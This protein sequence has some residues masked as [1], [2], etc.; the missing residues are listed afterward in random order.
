MKIQ[1]DPCVWNS[2]EVVANPSMT[3]KEIIVVCR[4]G[5]TSMHSAPRTK[6]A[7]SRAPPTT[8]PFYGQ[9]DAPGRSGDTRS[10]SLEQAQMNVV[11]AATSTGSSG[12]DHED[13]RLVGYSDWLRQEHLAMVAHVPVDNKKTS[14]PWTT[15][16]MGR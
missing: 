12:G 10:D 5:Q 8:T 11:T 7:P 9:H 3:Q 1:F 14:S 16:S 15:Q 6:A 13:P 2:L 4:N